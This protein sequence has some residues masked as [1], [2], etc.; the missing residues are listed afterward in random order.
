MMTIDTIPS[1]PNLIAND[2]AYAVRALSY[3]G[4]LLLASTPCLSYDHCRYLFLR[5]TS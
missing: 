3:V 5:T 1:F 4:S 2:E